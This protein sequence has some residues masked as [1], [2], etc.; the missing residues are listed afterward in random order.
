ML[1]Q[2]ILSQTYQRSCTDKK[3]SAF[4]DPSNFAISTASLLKYQI[5]I[6]EHSAVFLSPQK[7]SQLPFNT[8]YKRLVT[9]CLE[10]TGLKTNK[11]LLCTKFN[12]ICR[13]HRSCGAICIFITSLC[14]TGMRQKCISNLLYFANCG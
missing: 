2:K 4:T 7:I 3:P 6:A 11:M 8:Y 9:V 1:Q 10:A 14:N 5:Q 13:L 12:L